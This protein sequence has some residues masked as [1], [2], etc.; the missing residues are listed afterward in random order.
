MAHR[1]D[2]NSVTRD[3]SFCLPSPL[4]FLFY[5]K[6]LSL[7]QH[8]VMYDM[9]IVYDLYL[10]S[11]ELDVNFPADCALSINIQPYSR[12]RCAQLQQS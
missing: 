7:F 3:S 10:W 12:T 1:A 4:I 5:F 9:S 8:E 2:F 11:D 6:E